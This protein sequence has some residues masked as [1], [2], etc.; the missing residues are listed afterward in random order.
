MFSVCQMQGLFKMKRKLEQFSLFHFSLLR[1]ISP[2]E[3]IAVGGLR[4]FSSLQINVSHHENS[5]AFFFLYL[6]K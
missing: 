5:G 3:Q 2:G 6:E 1:P 4:E